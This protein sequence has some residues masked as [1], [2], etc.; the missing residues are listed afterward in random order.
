MQSSKLVQGHMNSLTPEQASLKSDNHSID[1]V[2]LNKSEN[3][4][5]TGEIFNLRDILNWPH[6]PEQNE[7]RKIER[8]TFVISS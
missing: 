4:L 5:T 6:F 2:L 7:T 8:T 1:N 3:Q